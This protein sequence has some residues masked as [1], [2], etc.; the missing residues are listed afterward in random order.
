MSGNAEFGGARV[1]AHSETIIG[2]AV[3]GKSQKTTPNQI[4]N[5]KGQT[6]MN[7]RTPVKIDMNKTN[8]HSNLSWL[9]AILIAVGVMA[10]LVWIAD[11]AKAW[12][13]S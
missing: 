12:K 7:E 4:V 10:P 1:A 13:G 5:T 8:Q 9:Y 6:N 2:A 3:L 11:H